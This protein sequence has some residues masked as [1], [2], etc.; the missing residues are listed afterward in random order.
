MIIG[1]AGKKQSGKSLAADA[2]VN[3]GFVKCSFAW[4]MKIFARN[5][6]RNIGM[7]EEQLLHAEEN[8][9]AV[10][11]KVGCSYRHFLQTLG[12]E[13]GRKHINKD[14][15][16]MCVEHDLKNLTEND[17]V[18][19][20]VRFENEA[21]LIRKKGGLIIHV[22]REQTDQFDHHASEAGINVL[23]GD[24]VLSNNGT[25]DEFLNAVF[26]VLDARLR[27]GG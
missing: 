14:L 21:D 8:K 10:I 9:E 13:W 3:S 19:D 16:V 7:S 24:V 22:S 15:W 12:T 17:V 18:F 1:F 25:H 20:D 26:D 23:P 2:L 27:N 11:L 5:L 4:S 6:L